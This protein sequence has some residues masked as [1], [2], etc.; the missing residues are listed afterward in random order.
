MTVTLRRTQKLATT[1]SVSSPD[2][3]PS[4]TALGDWYVNRFIVDRKPLLLLLSSRSLLPILLPARDLRS[5]P[6]R[7]CDVVGQRLRRFGIDSRLI[8]A[9][10]AAM[11]PVHVAK[12]ADRSVVGIMVD[13][14]NM[15]PYHLDAGAWDETT[16]PFAEA[17]LTET[18]CFASRGNVQ[19]V[20]PDQATPALLAQRWGAS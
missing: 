6:A 9:E 13:F 4:T 16:L 1:L 12:T 18:P 14:A 17:R 15:T 11:R 8:Q 5:L 3:P 10:L 19:T 2:P 20:F 7:L